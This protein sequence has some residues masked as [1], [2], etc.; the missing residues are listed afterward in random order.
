MKVT[1]VL[2][3]GFGA[4]APVLLS[5][6]IFLM[7]IRLQE[8]VWLRCW[9]Q[10]RTSQKE[11]NV[12]K[13]F[14]RYDSVRLCELNIVVICFISFRF[15]FFSFSK[16]ICWTSG[17]EPEQHRIMVLAPP[18]WCGS[19]LLALAPQYCTATPITL[20]NEAKQLGM[21]RIFGRIIRPFLYTV[22]GR[23]PDFIY[24]ISGRR[25]DTENSRISAQI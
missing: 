6:F 19:W 14:F 4:K 16:S 25:P 21:H 5:C 7:R 12:L 18:E 9:R 23:I 3:H 17:P 13:L 22:S 10:D 2:I 11:K 1:V 20:K 15:I 24:R 8:K